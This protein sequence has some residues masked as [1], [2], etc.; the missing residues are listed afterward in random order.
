MHNAN[1]ADVRACEVGAT[2]APFNVGFLN[3]VWI[4][5]GRVG[6]T[7]RPFRY[8]QSLHRLPY[9]LVLAAQPPRILTFFV[10]NNIFLFKIVFCV[11]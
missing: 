2:L 7:A 5:G 9:F 6:G 10:V 8:A 11:M 4:F 3:T 1:M